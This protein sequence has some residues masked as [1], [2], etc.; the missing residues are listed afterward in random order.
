MLKRIRKD[1]ESVL[2]K[3]AHGGGIATKE[4]NTGVISPKQRPAMA[5][6]ITRLPL[7][8]HLYL[9]GAGSAGPLQRPSPNSWD[10]R[11]TQPRI[12]EISLLGSY[13]VSP[14]LH[15]LPH[16]TSL[17]RPLPGAG[18]SRQLPAQ[19]RPPV[20]TF[21]FPCAHLGVPP[22]IFLER[23]VVGSWPCSVEGLKGW[24]VLVCYGSFALSR[25][26]LRS[27]PL[28]YDE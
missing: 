6:K 4:V 20:P 21:P 2:G 25:S 3:A 8:H 12:G 26:R 5:I 11:N 15:P 10:C 13:S 23:W 1:K 18:G 19:L 22:G 24:S 7:G 27:C 28:C 16:P 17:P 14:L 9:K